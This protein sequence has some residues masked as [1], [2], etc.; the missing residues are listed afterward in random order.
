[1]PERPQGLPNDPA[2][3]ESFA[4]RIEGAAVARAGALPWI[5]GHAPAVGMLALA[6]S[7]F[8][9]IAAARTHGGPALD[10]NLWTAAMAP[11]DP[12]GRSINAA[13]PPRLGQLVLV[14]R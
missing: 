5:A 3:W 11:S 10:A 1:M 2:Y 7:L 6:A 9:V 14:V 12:L 4:R 13:R 8:V